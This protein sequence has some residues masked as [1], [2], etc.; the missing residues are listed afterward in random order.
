MPA[1]FVIALDHLFAVLVVFHDTLD[2]ADHLL[3]KITVHRDDLE[4]LRLDI[5]HK[6]RITVDQHRLA[7]IEGFDQSVVSGFPGSTEVQLDMVPI[8]PAILSPSM[9]LPITSGV[10]TA[11]F[12]RSM[13]IWPVRR[14][15][16][17]FMPGL[18]GS[19]WLTR[20]IMCTII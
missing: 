3:R 7:M 11:R 12:W 1:E 16:G 13:P 9:I 17:T 18:S 10:R 4:P 14:R 5:G 6:D 19:Q 20:R 8:S 15:R 2:V